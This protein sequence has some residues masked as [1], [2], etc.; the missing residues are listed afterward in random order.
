MKKYILILFTL[1]LLSSASSQSPKIETAYVNTYVGVYKDGKADLHELISAPRIKHYNKNGQL[2]LDELLDSI[3]GTVIRSFRYHYLKSGQLK[4]EIYA[5]GDGSEYW[6]VTT[7]SYDS[8]NRLIKEENCDS[9]KL[10][11][12][13][14]TE[15]QYDQNSEICK[16]NFYD[17]GKLTGYQEF[18][19]TTLSSGQLQKKII[20][21]SAYN[22]PLY[23]KTKIYDNGNLISSTSDNMAKVITTY[24][25]Y[26]QN[27]NII[28]EKI[29]DKYD[30]SIYY[31]QYD[32]YGN[33]IVIAFVTPSGYGEITIKS[34]VYKE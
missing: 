25:E 2:I 30:E 34:Y 5:N 18:K 22:R 32:Q 4:H 11:C 20:E 26:D 29:G 7:Y 1:S 6:N 28:R 8:L 23:L 9:I 3:G 21:Y 14:K 24:Y 31:Y 13:I 27:G 15:Y 17:N 16:I 10:N 19:S 33:P 12:K